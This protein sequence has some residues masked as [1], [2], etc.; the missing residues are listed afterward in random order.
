MKKPVLS[1]LCFSSFSLVT[2]GLPLPLATHLPI[3]PA[4]LSPRAAQAATQK[5]PLRVVVL[6]FENLTRQEQ[7]AWLSHS[8]AES[9]TMGLVKV[10]ELHII[11]R[12]QIDKLLKE[13]QFSQ[14]A[15]ADPDTAPNL[16]RMLGANI[17][18]VG[19]YQKVGEQLQTLHKKDFSVVIKAWSFLL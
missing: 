4:A 6:P 17:V 5:G 2:A 7:D 12:S 11:E 18:A 14:S 10:K 8:F 1:L 19:S 13:Q 3:L 9:L 15:F 16:G